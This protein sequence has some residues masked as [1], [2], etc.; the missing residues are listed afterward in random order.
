MDSED[1]SNSSLN[2]EESGDIE[3]PEL[4]EEPYYPIKAFDMFKA[5]EV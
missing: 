4:P 5:F 2:G 1:N 3:I